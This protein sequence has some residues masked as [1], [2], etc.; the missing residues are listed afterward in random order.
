L[1]SGT[2]TLKSVWFLVGTFG[3][4]VWGGRQ[5]PAWRNPFE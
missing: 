2:E 3:P 5:T 1:K 4:R